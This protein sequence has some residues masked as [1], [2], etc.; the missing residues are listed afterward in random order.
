MGAGPD[1]CLRMRTSRSSMTSRGHETF[2][3]RRRANTWGW[4]FSCVTVRSLRVTCGDVII[5]PPCDSLEG[6]VSAFGGNTARRL[7]NASIGTSPLTEQP[8]ICSWSAA[9]RSCHPRVL[10]RIPTLNGE[11]A[12]PDSTF[13]WTC[14][15]PENDNV[16]DFK[17][18]R[19]VG[20]LLPATRVFSPD[21][22]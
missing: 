5:V 13:S 10:G 17:G 21:I 11:P 4:P 7:S 15:H 22:S 19:Y 6:R 9:Q 20:S 1:L 14:P 18:K 2:R 16:D 3:G 12:D 8:K